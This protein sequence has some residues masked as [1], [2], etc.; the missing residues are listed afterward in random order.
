MSR[1]RDDIVFIRKRRPDIEN[2]IK[3]IRGL[4][5]QSIAIGIAAELLREL[6]EA[7]ARAEVEPAPGMSISAP[8]TGAGASSTPDELDDLGERDPTTSSVPRAPTYCPEC[9]GRV[10]GG[11]CTLCGEEL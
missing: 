4:D 10:F 3:L 7:P 11:V 9:S 5:S 8:S 6:D 2:R 1:L